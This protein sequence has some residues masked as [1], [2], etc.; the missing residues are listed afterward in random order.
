MSVSFQSP[1]GTGTGRLACRVPTE[2]AKTDGRVYHFD[3]MVTPGLNGRG[4]GLFSLRDIVRTFTIE[5]DGEY[6]LRADGIPVELP[7]LLLIPRDQED[8]APG[9]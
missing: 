4:Y 1:G 3:W 9:G 6:R 2:F 5:M 8:A 7:S